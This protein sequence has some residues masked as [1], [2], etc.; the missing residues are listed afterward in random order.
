MGGLVGRYAAVAPREDPDA[1]LLD[2]V[3]LFTLGSPHRGA[4]VAELKLPHEMVEETRVDSDFILW[5]NEADAGRGYEIFPYVRL[6]DNVIGVA[7]AAPVGQHPWW[8]PNPAFEHPHILGALDKRFWADIARRLRGETA[9]T[10]PP[11]APPPS[12]QP[13]AAPPPGS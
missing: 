8:Q 3:R 11:P 10:K 1:R 5:M 12:E 6:G 9:Y 2:V 4:N 13:D 7:N